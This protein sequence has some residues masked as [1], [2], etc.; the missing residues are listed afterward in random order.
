VP[1]KRITRRLNAN[2]GEKM[3]TK[4]QNRLFVVAAVL[5]VIAL[6]IPLTEMQVS[7]NRAQ[8]ANM[9]DR[10]QAVRSFQK[11]ASRFPTHEELMQISQTLPDRYGYHP[12]YWLDKSPDENTHGWTL[13]FLRGE[14]A[15]R[16]TSWDDHYTLSD[17]VLW[18]PFWG[19]LW[20]PL[21]SSGLSSILLFA[22]AF[23]LKIK[24]RIA[25]HL[26]PSSNS[27]D[28]V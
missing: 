8:L 20:W 4:L 24:N 11:R 7:K 12:T 14:G 22:F 5:G 18:R 16:Y 2:V 3:K 17:Q 15:A 25:D 23:A 10:V 9:R 28:A 1:R 27:A 13:S 19:P 21:I 26:E 6:P